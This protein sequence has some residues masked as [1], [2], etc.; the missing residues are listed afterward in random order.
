MTNKLNIA[1]AI[2]LLI[3]SILFYWQYK[4]N[5]ALSEELAVFSEPIEE[6][7]ILSELIVEELADTD[8]PEPHRFTLINNTDN[9]VVNEVLPQNNEEL[10]LG[11]TEE[12]QV[13]IRDFDAGYFGALTFENQ[14]QYEWMVGHGYPTPEEILAAAQMSTEEL[15]ARADFGNVKAALFVA[16]RYLAEATAL[17][18]NLTKAG[19]PLDEDYAHLLKTAE[20]YGKVYSRSGSAFAGYLEVQLIIERKSRGPGTSLRSPVELAFKGFAFAAKRGDRTAK[21]RA[22]ELAQAVGADV[23]VYYR[24]GAY[25]RFL[26]RVAGVGCG[27][28]GWGRAKMMPSNKT[29]P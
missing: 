7:T 20:E 4:Q 18:E 11:F 22:I 17:A 6:L 24:F 10:W 21:A 14:K 5:Q 8:S 3:V 2:A 23:S 15:E 1:L 28:D 27:S 25:H 9:N 19:N 26:E 12:D 16:D 13:I 29:H